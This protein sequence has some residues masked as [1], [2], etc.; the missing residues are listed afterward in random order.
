MRNAYPSGVC[1]HGTV[2]PWCCAEFRRRCADGTIVRLCSAY[3]GGVCTGE[4]LVRRRLEQVCSSHLELGWRGRRH[5]ERGPVVQILNEQSR[6]RL[7]RME[8]EGERRAVSG[9]L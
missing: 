1:T 9:G 3:F 7:A 6:K 8:H 2:V 5:V 4:T